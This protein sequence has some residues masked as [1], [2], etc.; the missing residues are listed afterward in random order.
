[1]NTRVV[2]SG[3]CTSFRYVF[4]TRWS[5]EFEAKV[6]LK[7]SFHRNG[8]DASVSMAV[9]GEMGPSFDFTGL[10]S[11]TLQT[12]SNISTQI[13]E[14]GNLAATTNRTFY[15]GTLGAGKNVTHQVEVNGDVWVNVTTNVSVKLKIEEE[16]TTVVEGNCRAVR[17]FTWIRR[18]ASLRVNVNITLTF[19]SLNP[20]ATINFSVSVEGPDLVRVF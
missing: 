11:E 20:N 15:S 5:V 18:S 19:E 1:L 2:S 7:V 3:T 6:S 4:K 12:Q 16:K 14:A 17:S 13:E 8:T 10:A 9:T